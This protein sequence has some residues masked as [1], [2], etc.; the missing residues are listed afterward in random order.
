M[1][2]G[3]DREDG[4]DGEDRGD[5]KVCSNDF[6]RFLVTWLR[7]VTHFGGSASSP[8]TG[9]EASDC[10]CHDFSHDPRKIPPIFPI[11]PSSCFIR[12]KVKNPYPYAGVKLK[13][14]ISQPSSPF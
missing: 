10:A 6:S 12:L 13:L 4:G 2:D 11:H 14:T 7:R 9:A 5:G 1:R 8:N 3:G